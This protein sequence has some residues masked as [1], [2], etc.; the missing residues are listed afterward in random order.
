MHLRSSVSFIS[1][2]K[3]DAQNGLQIGSGNLDVFF[4]AQPREGIQKFRL[5]H[6]VA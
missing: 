2:E 5:L 1:T 6:T 4:L 3:G